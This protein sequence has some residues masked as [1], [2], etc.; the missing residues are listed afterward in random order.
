MSDPHAALRDEV[1]RRVLDGPA[2][3]APALRHAA[4]DDAHL[5]PD[6]QSLVGKIHAHAY[7]VTDADVAAAQATYGDDVMF[8]VVVS[9]ALGA[10]RARLDAAL[11]ALED[12]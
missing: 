7:R 1:L 3:S 12:A 10:S 9:A 6:L 8:E 11:K 5:S 2:E 4:A